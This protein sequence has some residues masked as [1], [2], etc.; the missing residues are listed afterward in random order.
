M[1]YQDNIE[2]NFLLKPM[3]LNKLFLYQIGHI[4]CD[5][6]NII[7]KHAQLNFFELTI[8]T[9]GKGIIRSNDV[10]SK[11]SQG[12]IYISFPGDF[13]EIE[14]TVENPLSF[15]F[16]TF[17]TQKNKLKCELESIQ[18]NFAPPNRRI[19]KNNKIIELVELL[20]TEISN[21]EYLSSEILR[22]SLIEL[23]VYLI[24]DFKKMNSKEDFSTSETNLLCLKLMRY[25]DTHIFTLNSLE[26]LSEIFSYNYSYIS[27]IFNQHTSKTLFEYYQSRRMKTAKLMIAEGHFSITQ[28]SEM[29]NY[30]SVYSFSRAFKQ[31][32]GYPPRNTRK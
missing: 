16:I 18:T 7:E 19:I 21:N 22:A 1:K 28:I 15:Y 4:N 29:L 30:S 26:E 6:I 31:Y 12:D 23:I 14:S 27:S 9:G 3:E 32:Y 11:V 2:H 17:N 13:H 5:E 20:L 25:I 10:P 24:R 8:I